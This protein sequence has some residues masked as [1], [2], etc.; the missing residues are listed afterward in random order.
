MTFLLI[1]KIILLIAA[2]LTAVASIGANSNALGNRCVVLTA[3][4]VAALVG[5][6]V[7]EMTRGIGA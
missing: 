4:F 7:F 2:L 3:V 1:V 5:L 6:I